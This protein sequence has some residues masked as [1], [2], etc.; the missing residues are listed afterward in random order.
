[1]SNK[2][3]IQAT[4]N[5]LTIPSEYNRAKVKQMI[6]DGT[7]LFELTPRIRASKKQTGYLEGAV[8]FAWAK[9]QYD[10]DPRNPHNH[11]KAR[12]L[13]KQ[14][15]WFEIIKDRNGNP[16][17]TLKSLAGSH[18]EALNTYT[19]QATENGFPIPNE[20]LYLKWRDEW[21][22]EPRFSSYYDWLNFLGLDEDSMP[23]AETFKKLE[24]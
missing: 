16:K 9:F 2:I 3:L 18:A 12:N 11:E 23:S 15:F 4:E 1:M 8:I 6:K 21:S 22:M 17:K 20:K 13:F 10:L 24:Q 19:E 7:T 14:D 5:G